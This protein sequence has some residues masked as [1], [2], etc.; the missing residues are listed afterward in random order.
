MLKTVVIVVMIMSL[1]DLGATYVYISTFA[2]KFPELDAISLEANPILKLAMRQLGIEKGMI[3][4][5]IVVFLL[6]LIIITSLPEKW[7]FFL[8]G[9]L[10]TTLLVH[11]LNFNQL[12]GLK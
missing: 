10:A 4:G 7:Q 1:L 11:L 12:I 6:L 9:V 8:A 3:F 2:H 5:G